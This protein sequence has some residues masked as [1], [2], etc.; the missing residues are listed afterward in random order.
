MFRFKIQIPV[1]HHHVSALYQ[2]LV[3]LSLTKSWHIAI[4]HFSEYLKQA[5]NKH[6]HL[7]AVKDAEAALRAVMQQSWFYF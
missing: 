1:F 7:V 2:E 6:S 4:V 5:R 3:P